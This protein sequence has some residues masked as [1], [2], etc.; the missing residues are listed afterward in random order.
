MPPGGQSKGGQTQPDSITGNLI[1]LKACT[2][3]LATSTQQW[4]SQNLTLDQIRG[5]KWLFMAYH[6]YD[7]FM[8]VR[9]FPN[10]EEHRQAVLKNIRACAEEQA[11]KNESKK[12]YTLF[13]FAPS[14]ASEVAQAIPMNLIEQYLDHIEASQRED[15][16]WDDEHDLPYWQPYASIM[17]LLALKNFN[18]L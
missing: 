18:R 17:S 13:S 7:Y 6:A 10:L 14:P 11:R 15:G 9:T 12:Y 3:G 2:P 1:R 4:V 5:N 8:N 16:G